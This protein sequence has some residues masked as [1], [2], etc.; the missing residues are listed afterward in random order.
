MASVPVPMYLNH[1]KRTIIS[2]Y[3]SSI[4]IIMFLDTLNVVYTHSINCNVTSYRMGVLSCLNMLMSIGTN[5]GPRRNT[6]TLEYIPEPIAIWSLQEKVRTAEK[7]MHS[8]SKQY[9]ST[10]EA[11]LK[12]M[13]RHVPSPFIP[14]V[15]ETQ[16]CSTGCR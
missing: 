13:T 3:A 14:K 15:P 8:S 9:D 5:R 1:I 11:S 12:D 7:S 16:S 4:E 6:S 2:G 10:E